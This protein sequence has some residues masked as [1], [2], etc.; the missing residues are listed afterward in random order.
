M[1]QPRASAS[2]GTCHTCKLWPCLGTTQSRGSERVPGVPQATCMLYGGTGTVSFWL[3]GLPLQPGHSVLLHTANP[4]PPHSPFQLQRAM[5]HLRGESL[6]PPTLC[7]DHRDHV[8]QTQVL[9]VTSISLSPAGEGSLFLFDRP[10][11]FPSEARCGLSVS[12]SFA[13]VDGPLCVLYSPGARKRTVNRSEAL[14]GIS[15]QELT[16]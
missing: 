12:P 4:V 10:R 14:L 13:G 3:Q 15:S 9:F 6:S 2:H 1:A 11:S 5:R 16:H 7:G 8:H